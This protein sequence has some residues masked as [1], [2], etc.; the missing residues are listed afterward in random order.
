MVQNK[1]AW[2]HGAARAVKAIFAVLGALTIVFFA[3]SAAN[4]QRSRL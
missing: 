4:F 2:K 3:F 1:T